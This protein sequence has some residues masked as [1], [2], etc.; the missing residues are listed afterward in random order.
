[1]A[2]VTTSEM[3]SVL[4]LALNR[5][6]RARLPMEPVW[7]EF[8]DKEWVY[9]LDLQDAIERADHRLGF[10]PIEPKFLAGLLELPWRYVVDRP[11]HHHDDPTGFKALD[12]AD[13][14]AVLI[15]LERLGFQIDPGP[16]CTLL[17]DRLSDSSRLTFV[18]TQVLFHHKTTGRTAPLSLTAADNDDWS[19]ETV[20]S[21]KTGA[22][23]RIEYAANSKGQGLWISVSAPR[24]RPRP[25]PVL[26]R[27]PDCGVSWVKGLP[28]EDKSHRTMHRIRLAVLHPRPN[29]AFLK[30]R[31]RDELAA[32]WVNYRSP[33]WKHELMYRR[34]FAF[35][36]EFGYDFS[37]WARNPLDDPEPEG[38]LFSDDDGRVI[39]AA[40]FRPQSDADRPWR[41]DWVWIAPDHR[42]QGH[43][44][45][46]WS[47]FRQSYGEFDMTPP[48]SDAMQAFLK[49]R[50]GI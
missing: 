26:T 16:L 18:E 37:Q 45:R 2:F 48:V 14:A 43:L 44:G 38:F 36:R 9:D 27:C 11:A 17:R 19:G 34:A 15:L 49:S 33:Q 35:K 22:G 30:A 20:H 50:G 10:G 6:T 5:P 1:M 4:W 42:R 24:F 23:Y 7:Q 46:Q 3:L 12:W 29:R 21:L 31:D 41:L 8:A 28:A 13:A 47:L 25:E 39:G 32:P 40:A